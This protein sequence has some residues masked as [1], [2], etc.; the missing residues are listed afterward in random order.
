MHTRYAAVTHVL[1]ITCPAESAPS[2]HPAPS[3]CNLP[4]FWGHNNAGKHALRT[5]TSIHY[6]S[7]SAAV[8]S[9]KGSIDSEGA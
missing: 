3:T 1:A 7:C 9:L 6:P 2:H 4:S 8:S 5:R